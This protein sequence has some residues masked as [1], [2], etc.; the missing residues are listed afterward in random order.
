MIAVIADDFTGAAEIG[1][2][3][4]RRGLKVLIETSVTGSAD[5]E[6]LVIA[7]DTRS[8]TA[9][10][11]RLEIEQ[12]TRRLLALSPRYIFKKLDS[13]LRGNI[14]DELIVQQRVSGKKRVIVVPANPHFNRII[15]NGIYYINDVPLAETSFANDPEFPVKDSDVREIIGRDKPGLYAMNVDEYLYG[16]G[17]IIGNVVSEAELISWAGKVDE[18]SLAAGGSGFFD[19]LLQRDFPMRQAVSAPDSFSGKNALF[20]FGS[21]YPKET[22]TM[23][24]FREAGAAIIN[25]PDLLFNGKLTKEQLLIWSEKITGELRLK[26]KVALTTIFTDERIPATVIRLVTGQLVK[27]VFERIQIDD[28]FIEGGATAFQILNNLGIRQLTPCRELDFGI[29]Q[30]HAGGIFNLCI[31]TKPGSYSWPDLII[32][33]KTFKLNKT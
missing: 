2:M 23:N 28:L 14:Y 22:A 27:A 11:A 30:M 6:L 17:M 13:V 16:E 24:K 26:G 20:I 10:A 31:T 33:N 18:D 15:R 7:T 9:A 25:L 32:G 4:L 3:G 29:I 5:A 21:A 19:A 1:G 12:V 8:M